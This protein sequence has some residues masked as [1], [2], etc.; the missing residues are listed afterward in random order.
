MPWV[1]EEKEKRKKK[2][3]NSRTERERAKE[4]N[5]ISAWSEGKIL[6]KRGSRT[7]KAQQ[8]VREGQGE[9]ARAEIRS[10]SHHLIT[11]LEMK[12]QSI[13]NG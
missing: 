5:V 11:S 2:S 9:D 13:S 8:E 1:Q 6:G 3:P 12:F 10:L 7:S 4:Y